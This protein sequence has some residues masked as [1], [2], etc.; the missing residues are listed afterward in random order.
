MTKTFTAT[1]TFP[2]E[3]SHIKEMTIEITTKCP[4]HCLHCSTNA[5]PNGDQNL[6]R[7]HVLKII[8][9][10]IEL[11]A[12]K[13]NLSGGEPF[14]HPDIDGILLQARKI[15]SKLFLYSSGNMPSANGMIQPISDKFIESTAGLGVRFVFDIQGANNN[16]HDYITARKG[17]F[18]NLIMSVQ[19]ACEH[20]VPFEFHFV[21]MR[22]NFKELKEVVFMAERM[23]AEKVS[24]LRFVPQ[25]RGKAN[26]KKLNLAPIH[27]S[28]LR[29]ILVHLQDEFSGFI[30]LGSPW[31]ALRL[32][33]PTPCASGLGKVLIN[34]RG[35]AHVCEAFKH[36]TK[37][38]DIINGSLREFL[39][40]TS[41]LR[42]LDFLKDRR[43]F[44][45]T[46]QWRIKGCIAQATLER[47]T[48]DT[49]TD[50]LYEIMNLLEVNSSKR[51]T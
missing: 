44:R 30:R 2:R 15:G 4:L 49:L 18:Q 20:G 3:N 19:K 35:E 25:G 13:V 11:G 50:P 31:N 24:I 9:E 22:P 48:S 17:S 7:F 21:P 27:V 42:F 12:K 32:G 26:K 29:E 33:E 38:Y 1:S 47:Q 46:P 10:S 6:S 14:A 34:P 40:M 16:T 36:L 37:G 51:V 23:G 5:G 28:Q 45:V 43:N 8:R 41:R 39:R